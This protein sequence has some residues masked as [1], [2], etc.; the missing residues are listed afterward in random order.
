MPIR[1][2][3]FKLE[4]TDNNLQS[5]K[6]RK[7]KNRILLIEKHVDEWMIYS[8]YEKD[9]MDYLGHP[10]DRPCVIEYPL[11]QDI[12]RWIKRMGGYK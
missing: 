4:H 10:T 6:W 3:D 2:E 11:L 9:D 8:Y 5:F 12:N 7:D 1:L